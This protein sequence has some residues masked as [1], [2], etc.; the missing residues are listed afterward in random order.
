MTKTGRPVK[1]AIIVNGEVVGRVCSRCSKPKAAE[2]FGKD[3]RNSTGL[4]SWCKS[5]IA[6]RQ[7]ERTKA[8]PEEGERRRRYKA[9]WLAAHPDARK[10]IGRKQSADYR[11]RHP[12]RVKD[13]AEAGA[14]YRDKILAIF[15]RCMACGS[16]EDLT[17]DHVTPLGQEEATN[18]PDNIQVLCRSCNSGKADQ[19]IDY[20]TSE[21]RSVLANL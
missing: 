7:A 17:L 5:C 21:Q 6:E 14:L 10:R 3:K 11:Q 13:R 9:E 16:S 2:E 19:N 15:N 20:R 12:K 4:Q 18:S 8:N 1:G